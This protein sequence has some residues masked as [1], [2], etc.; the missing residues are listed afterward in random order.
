MDISRINNFILCFTKTRIY[1]NINSYINKLFT[2]CIILFCVKEYYCLTSIFIC[3]EIQL[4]LF[5]YIIEFLIYYCACYSM[6]KCSFYLCNHIIIIYPTEP[7]MRIFIT[8]IHH[9]NIFFT[10]LSDYVKLA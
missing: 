7:A 6:A 3:M 2:S 5:C 1:I 8:F 4:I 9:C 10:L